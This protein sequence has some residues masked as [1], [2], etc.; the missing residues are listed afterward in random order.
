MVSN[1]NAGKTTLFNCLTGLR[2]KTANFPGTTIELRLARRTFGSANVELIDMPGLYSLTGVSSEE[3]V[4]LDGILGRGSERHR[5]DGLILLLDATN[6]ERNLFLASQVLELGL[7]IVVALNMIDVAERE[8]IQID[9]EALAEELDCPVMPMAAKTGR[10]FRPFRDRLGEFAARARETPPPRLPEMLRG[11]TDP[12]AHRRYDWAEAVAARCVK[13]P[14]ANERTLTQ[15]LDRVLTDEFWGVTAF[16]AVMAAVF[17]AIFSLATVPMDTIDFFFGTVGGWVGSLIPA[18]E[19]RGLMVEGVV[20]G[21]GG[22][23]VFLPQIC[24]LFFLISLLEDTGYLARAAFVMDRL[25]GRFGLPG[26]AFVPMLSAHACAIPAIMSA[27]VI[28][29]R[30]DRLVTILVLPLMTCSARL[31]VYAMVTAML[32]PS[33]PLMGA[34]VFT[35]AYALGGVAALTMAFVFRRTILPGRTSPLVIELPSY[36]MPSLRTA[37]LLTIDR[38]RLFVRKAGT[39]ILAISIVLWAL[40]SYPGPPAGAVAE[41]EMEAEVAA[42]ESAG[43]LE[44][45]ALTRAAI[46][47]VESK[48]ELRYSI[49]GRLGR[50]F[51]PI[52]EPLGFDWRVGVAIIASFA[53]REVVVSA[54]SVIY[55]VGD[56]AGEEGVLISRMKAARRMGGD[57]GP[58]FTFASCVSLLVFYV[59]AMQCLPTQVVTQR[60]TGHW[61]W[62]ALQLGYMSVLAYVAAMVAYQGITALGWDRAI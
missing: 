55:G 14:A 18:G 2:A 34:V 35:G 62:A 12:E 44:A 26:K 9:A 25:M 45:A 46:D 59:L 27:R 39:V 1:P 30:R 19:L 33:D 5:P 32:F 13:R 56:D 21:V 58:V 47:R 48:V 31:P 57:G 61:K 11:L 6:L 17:F 36:K 16:L 51:E 23:L 22:V 52:V 7:P 53:A 8:G 38:A 24:L 40:L 49:G 43:D 4:A 10:G 28:E 37:V 60:E 42:L 20:A 50:L 54:L 41:A 3:R 29:N 15:R